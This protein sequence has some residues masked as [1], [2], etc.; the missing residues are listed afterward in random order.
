M[1][2]WSSS[3][4]G[5]VFRNTLSWGSPCELIPTKMVSNIFFFRG[6]GSKQLDHPCAV[7]CNL[8][9]VHFRL[10]YSYSLLNL[11]SSKCI[12]F[13]PS[14]ISVLSVPPLFLSSKFWPCNP[15][16]FSARWLFHILVFNNRYFLWKSSEPC[17]LVSGQIKWLEEI[18]E[19]EV[20]PK[21]RNVWSNLTAKERWNT[22]RQNK[23]YCLLTF[24]T[25]DF[26][27]AGG[28]NASMVM[29]VSSW[30]YFPFCFPQRG[31]FF[32]RTPTLLI[33]FPP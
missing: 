9:S 24:H 18:T 11:Q 4:S 6:G 14:V 8:A 33:A 23:S 13:Q 31:K 16:V 17:Y 21:I 3:S 10:L 12:L 5:A 29:M 1:T 27:S 2:R 22:I 19:F 7:D 15:A 20:K 30:Y 32:S 28:H 26:Y 25:V